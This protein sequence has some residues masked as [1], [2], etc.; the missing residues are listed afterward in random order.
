MR[1][2]LNVSTATI[3]VFC[4]LLETTRPTR[5]LRRVFSATPL[6]LGGREGGLQFSLALYGLDAGDAPP[7]P[8]RLT[9]VGQLSGRELEAQGEQL[10]V[11]LAKLFDQVLVGLGAQV[12]LSLVW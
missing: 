7:R 12:L 2:R 6:L 1:W 9:D 4:I 10:P 5:S 11:G 3:T 8:A